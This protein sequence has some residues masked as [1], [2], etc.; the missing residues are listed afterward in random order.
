MTPSMVLTVVVV[1]QYQTHSAHDD[2][3]Q[4]TDVFEHPHAARGGR[5]ED[6]RGGS[7]LYVGWTIC[8]VPAARFSSR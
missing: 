5:L 8:A 1:V 4:D 2:R 6:L 3:K 7:D